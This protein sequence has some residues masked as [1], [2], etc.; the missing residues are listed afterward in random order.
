MAVTPAVY[1]STAQRAAVVCATAR[2]TA[3]RIGKTIAATSCDV[4]RQ[5]GLSSSANVLARRSKGE[6]AD[7]YVLL[8]GVHVAVLHASLDRRSWERDLHDA[9]VGEAPD[10]DA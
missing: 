9:N 1:A 3:P 2:S 6:L 5:R 8:A 7:G 4:P 10:A